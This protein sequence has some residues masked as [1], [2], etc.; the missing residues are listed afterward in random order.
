[1]LIKM[2]PPL[3]KGQKELTWLEHRCS[4]G[5]SSAGGLWRR[6]GLGSSCLKPEQ[7]CSCWL[8]KAPSLHRPSRWKPHPLHCGHWQ[9]PFKVGSPK[10]CPCCS[11]GLNASWDHIQELFGR[12]LRGREVSVRTP[13]N[14]TRWPVK[15]PDKCQAGGSEGPVLLW[16]PGF[17]GL[18]WNPK[19]G[20]ENADYGAGDALY[21][22]SGGLSGTAI[23]GLFPSDA[24]SLKLS[25]VNQWERFP[26]RLRYRLAYIYCVTVLKINRFTY[27]L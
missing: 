2:K 15:A 13:T 12:S 9:N 3:Q 24:V 10:I 27:K 26:H 19:E 8:Q 23:F 14:L 21:G 18:V 1:M 17:P 22:G 5:R 11:V 7:G 25:L 20:S 4:S 16:E 6:P